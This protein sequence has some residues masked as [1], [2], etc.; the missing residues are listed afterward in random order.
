MLKT[1]GAMTIRENIVNVFGAKQIST[2]IDVEI[3]HPD[4]TILKEYSLTLVPGEKLPFSLE[5]CISSVMYGYGRSSADRQFYYINSRPCEPTKIM[6][7]VNQVYKQFNAHQYPFVFLNIIMEKSQIDVNVTPDKRQIFLAKEKLLS[8]TIKMSLMDAFKTFPSTYKIQ[9]VG[10]TKLMDVFRE[11]SQA[12]ND[13]VKTCNKGIKRFLTEPTKDKT[14]I[15]TGCIFETFKKRSKMDDSS[16]KETKSKTSLSQFKEENEKEK[17]IS[18]E[19]H[20][21]LKT[22]LKLAYTLE[23]EKKE[24][25][26]HVQVPNKNQARAKTEIKNETFADDSD[27]TVIALDEEVEVKVR[28]TVALDV[29]INDVRKALDKIN[30]A[31]DGK[32]KQFTVKFRSKISPEANATAEK[33]LEKQIS[34][35]MFKAME[36]IGQFNHGF[37][38]TKLNDDLF[39]IDQ[40]ATDEKYNFEQLQITTVLENQV[41]V[42]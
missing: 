37:I 2:L 21:N 29:S 6:K 22:L 26:V 11:T 13:S 41:L 36:I 32:A 25:V 42:K 17:E 27:E 7:L 23:Q 12:E 30:L 28:K 31:T 8:A 14:D 15:Q 20:K 35:C 10:V 18:D 24:N 9:N 33:E 39:I 3:V 40:H 38:I 5:F 16:I 4:E 19:S 34:K 1:E